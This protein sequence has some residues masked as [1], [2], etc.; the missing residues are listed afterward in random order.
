M[1]C[2]AQPR[3][4]MPVRHDYTVT[5]QA[6]EPLSSIQGNLAV[7]SPPKISNS[8]LERFHVLRLLLFEVQIR[9]HSHFNQN[10]TAYARLKR[11]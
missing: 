7:N 3:Q 1:R 11:S 9:A 10:Y 2:P 5:T 8:P 4:T 6:L